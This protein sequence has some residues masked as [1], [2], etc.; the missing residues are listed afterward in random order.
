MF[1]TKLLCSISSFYIESE[2]HGRMCLCRADSDLVQF[3]DIP[4]MIIYACMQGI[5]M[6]NW[7]FTS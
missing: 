7:L 3:Y 5:N 1:N 6:N 2:T 4:T